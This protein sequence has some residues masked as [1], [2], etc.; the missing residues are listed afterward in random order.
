MITQLELG[1]TVGLTVSL[2]SI[3]FWRLA[4]DTL[5]ITCNFLYCNHQVH[6]DFLI[7]LYKGD[8]PQSFHTKNHLELPF[9]SSTSTSSAMCIIILLSLSKRTGIAQSVQ[10]PATD[11][12]VRGSIP[13]EARYS[14]P[15]LEHTQPP[16]QW[17]SDFFPGDK[18]TVVWRWLPTPSR[19]EVKERV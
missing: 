10:R 16:T 4:G 12:T 5:N 15:A 9:P 8:S 6:R 19:A 18:A 11:W 2:V 14:R 3:N 7:T 1:I 17:V 13:S